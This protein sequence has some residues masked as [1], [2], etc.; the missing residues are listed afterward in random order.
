MKEL[1]VV[2]VAPHLL[3]GRVTVGAGLDLAHLLAA[4]PA[5]HDVGRLE[6]LVGDVTR[7]V[8]LPLGVLGRVGVV[9][10]PRH[11]ISLGL[12]CDDPSATTLVTVWPNGCVSTAT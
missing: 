7:P 5:L 10:R 4:V 3:G 1:L 2:H 12:S 8:S 11:F 9:L 6:L